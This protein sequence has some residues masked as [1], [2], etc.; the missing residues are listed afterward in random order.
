MTSQATPGAIRAKLDAVGVQ[1]RHL[2]HAPTHT[3]QESAAARGEPLENGA[4]AI[5][6][7]VDGDF[8]LLVMS[9]AA[10]LHTATSRASLGVRDIRFATLDELKALT[11]LEPGGVPPFGR[12]ILPLDLYVD[13]G[14]PALE[15]VA[16]N[17][18]SLTESIIMSAKDYLAVAR[19]VAVVS[20]THRL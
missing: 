20:L 15:R 6:A 2:T 19:P 11:G 1:Y 16:F 13:E 3:S 8:R 14:I 10:R 9:A 17:A 12:P 18:A 5:V 4:K 7:K